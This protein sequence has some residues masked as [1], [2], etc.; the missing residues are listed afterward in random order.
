MEVYVDTVGRNEKAIKEYACNQLHE[1]IGCDQMCLRGFKDL[2]MGELV[3][4][5]K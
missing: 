1:D 4:K 5:G 2:F 3:V